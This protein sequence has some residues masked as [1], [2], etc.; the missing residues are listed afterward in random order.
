MFWGTYY[1][2]LDIIKFEMTGNVTKIK[3]V[4]HVNRY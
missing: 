4:I 1:T 2:L 3:D